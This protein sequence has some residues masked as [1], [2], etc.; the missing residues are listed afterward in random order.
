MTR[1]IAILLTTLLAAG[2]TLLEPAPSSSRTAPAAPGEWKLS[3][4]QLTRSELAQTTRGEFLSLLWSKQ[5]PQPLGETFVSD[6]AIVVQNPTRMRYELPHPDVAVTVT[7]APEIVTADNAL[8]HGDEG[9]LEITSREGDRLSGLLQC[10]VVD[11]AH[12]DARYLVIA[13]F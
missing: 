12:G 9:F 2:C 6:L 13:R 11:S 5:L 8:L 7:R 4:A 3:G 10:K 1:A